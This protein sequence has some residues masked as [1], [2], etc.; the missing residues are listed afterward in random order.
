MEGRVSLVKILRKA[1]NCDGGNGSLQILLI[2]SK[3]FHDFP[4]AATSESFS[5]DFY[6]YYLFSLNWVHSVWPR[7]YVIYW[8]PKLFVFLALTFF[9]V[10]LVA[11]LFRSGAESFVS[12]SQDSPRSDAA[13]LCCGR[14]NSWRLAFRSDLNGRVDLYTIKAAN[15]TNYAVFCIF[16]IEK[17]SYSVYDSSKVDFKNSKRCNYSKSPHFHGFER[18]LLNVKTISFPKS[19]PTKTF[20]FLRSW[21]SY[22]LFVRQS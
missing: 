20:H 8:S 12:R 1:K 6:F 4:E 17:S 7:C 5:A 19:K 10:S 3:C 15:N 11:W 21:L 18:V 13:D 16:S 14:R 9:L 22:L 2:A